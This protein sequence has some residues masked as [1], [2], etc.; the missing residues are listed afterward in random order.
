MRHVIDKNK[1]V[2]GVLSAQMEFGRWGVKLSTDDNRGGQIDNQSLGCN[3]YFSRLVMESLIP[4]LRLRRLY[5][6]MKYIY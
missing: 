3:L 2:C 6:R 1:G 5:N 4:A